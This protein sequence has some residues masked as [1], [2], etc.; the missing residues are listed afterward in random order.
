MTCIVQI[1]EGDIRHT[2]N[3]ISSRKGFTK[4]YT[5][6]DV[7][8]SV[9]ELILVW[10]RWSILDWTF[11]IKSM[12][13]FHATNTCNRIGLHLNDVVVTHATLCI[14]CKLAENSDFNMHCNNAG[15]LLM[16]P[17]KNVCILHLHVITTRTVY[18]ESMGFKSIWFPLLWL[19][20]DFLLKPQ[21]DATFAVVSS[22]SSWTYWSA[23]ICS[24][25]I[26]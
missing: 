6:K 4:V 25:G 7:L 8:K 1:E 9:S 13:V 24:D 18:V 23:V 22:S 14:I 16:H 2:K 26:W 11:Q 20:I 5:N 19:P 15:A 17:L 10:N 3:E 21:T 12:N